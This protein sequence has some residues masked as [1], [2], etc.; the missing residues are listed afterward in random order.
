MCVPHMTLRYMCLCPSPLH[1]TPPLHFAPPTHA[2]ACTLLCL[3]LWQGVD[4][5]W[6]Q[7]ITPMSLISII[8]LITSVLGRRGRVGAVQEV[9][10]QGG[11]RGVVTHEAEVW[12]R[13]GWWWQAGP[14]LFSGGCKYLG[15]GK[16]QKEDAGGEQATPQSNT[17]GLLLCSPTGRF[18]R[19]K[20]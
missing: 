17:G 9:W 10:S 5:G 11:M 2:R 12:G 4:G 7:L 6:E 19:W 8:T 1:P 14:R 20:C 16:K 15:K 13:W 18:L 3:L